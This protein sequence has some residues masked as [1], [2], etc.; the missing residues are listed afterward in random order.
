MTMSTTGL[1][2]IA[3]LASHLSPEEQLQLIL[4]IQQQLP[5]GADPTASGDV[6]CGSPASIL[7]A[8]SELPHVESEAVDELEQ[9]IAAGKMPIGQEGAFDKGD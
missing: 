7:S 5:V 9:A 6:I 4:R 1:Q 3:E 8:I 2:Q